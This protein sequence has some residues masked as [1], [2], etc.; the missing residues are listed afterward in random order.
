MSIRPLP[1]HLQFLFAIWLSFVPL[2]HP[3]WASSKDDLARSF[4]RVILKGDPQQAGSRVL[5]LVR[6]DRKAQDGLQKL[7]NAAVRGS[8]DA[9]KG[10]VRR[11]GKAL[12]QLEEEVG[13]DKVK[14]FL[15]DYDDLQGWAKNRPAG[16]AAEALK[17][18]D[19]L[20]KNFAVLSRGKGASR[21][22]AFELH[23]AAHYAKRTTPPKLR[24]I[25]PKAGNNVDYTDLEV[26]NGETIL[27]E[28]KSW[29]RMTAKRGEKRLRKQADSH[30]DR[31]RR[32]E[33]PAV[34]PP[35]TR[36]IF[37]FHQRLLRKWERAIEQRV[38]QALRKHWGCSADQARHWV[39]AGN[40]EIVKLT[41][42]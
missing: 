29:F 1:R 8:D 23:R 17:E 25:Q 31:L 9:A 39:D 38:R 33:T 35:A 24:K 5:D 22:Y 26:G 34:C 28:A 12:T 16:E 2:A 21:G 42:F 4:V 14:Q 15:R 10:T 30:V 13:P 36:M 11:V 6:G 27:I 20:A 32:R 19:T 18:I 7:V 3:V 40:L 37:E 41:A